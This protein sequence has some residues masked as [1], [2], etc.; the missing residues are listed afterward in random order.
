M[1]RI[2]KYNHVYAVA[3]GVLYAAFFALVLVFIILSTWT[4]TSLIA[5]WGVLI[6]M[7]FVVTA[8][9][10]HVRSFFGIS[11][12]LCNDCCW[13]CWCV[14]YTIGQMQMQVEDVEAA[15]HSSTMPAYQA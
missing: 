5:L 3:F 12:N 8:A 13:S 11:G 9:R 14:N 2:T 6:L 1:A 7:S 10:C 4:Y 15:P